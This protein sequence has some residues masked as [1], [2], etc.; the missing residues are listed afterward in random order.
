MEWTEVLHQILFPDSILQPT[1]FGSV[2][3]LLLSIFEGLINPGV[4]TILLK[5]LSFTI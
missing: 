2:P 3:E 4:N 5:I 1:F